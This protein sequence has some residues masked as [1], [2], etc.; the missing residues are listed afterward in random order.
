MTDTKWIKRAACGGVTEI[1][2]PERLTERTVAKA[3]S[4]CKHCPVVKDCLDYHFQHEGPR[5]D[6]DIDYGIAAG[7]T[8]D[9]RRRFYR[10]AKYGD[11]WNDKQRQ[12][13]E[14]TATH[15]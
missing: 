4:I 10:R 2:F 13:R 6:I 14:R 3:K 9:E 11:G 1:F 12:Y 7:M 5:G 15:D 8:S